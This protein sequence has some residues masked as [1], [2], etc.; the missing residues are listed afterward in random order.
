MFKELQ[1]GHTVFDIN[2]ET[3]NIFKDLSS[4]FQ[5]E[6][7]PIFSKGPINKRLDNYVIILNTWLSIQSSKK[8]IYF[9]ADKIMLFASDYFILEQISINPELDLYLKKIQHNPNLEF[10]LAYFITEQLILWVNDVLK[11]NHSTSQI[12]EE[13][14]NR[15][16]FALEK[17]LSVATIK[18]HNISVE[19]LQVTQQLTYNIKTTSDFSNAITHAIKETEAYSQQ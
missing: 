18:T 14:I 16:Y 8:P 2:E 17:S 15:P 12:L 6:I 3:L 19:Q 13:I 11:T 1:L 9:N 7:S 5:H 10:A 4:D